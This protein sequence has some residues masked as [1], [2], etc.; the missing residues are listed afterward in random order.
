M[1]NVL[2]DQPKDFVVNSN[3]YK[4]LG[5]YSESFYPKRPVLDGS[6]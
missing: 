4:L 1:V 5:V 3:F 2:S 6:C